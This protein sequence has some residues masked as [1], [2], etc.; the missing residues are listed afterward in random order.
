MK[1][2]DRQKKKTAH[3]KDPSRLLQADPMTLRTRFSGLLY[4]SLLLG[5]QIGLISGWNVYRG[6]QAEFD[7]GLLDLTPFLLPVVVALTAM[8]WFLPALLPNRTHL[9]SISFITMFGILLYV[10]GNFLVWD[11][12]VFDGGQVPWARHQ[13]KGWLETAL[14]T[15]T[16]A[17]A[18]FRPGALSRFSRT[19]C[20]AL[21][22]LQ[23][24]SLMVAS[25]SSEEG[26]WHREGSFADMPAEEIYQ[27]S[28][29]R[30]VVHLVLDAFQTDVFME[31]VSEESLSEELD[32]FLF[33]QDNL[34][35]AAHT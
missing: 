21:I 8:F 4:P 16:L 34:G 9:R 35:V 2:R 18:L 24:G 3:R 26:F 12:G 14:W 28:Q 5:L 1:K 17:W 29:N 23:I 22:G 27:Y 25:F 31:L 7:H 20:L 13:S 30:N 19:I 11:Y 10:Q 33:Y 6:N 32:G 15:G